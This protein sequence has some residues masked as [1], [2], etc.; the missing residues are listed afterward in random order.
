MDAIR[1]LFH[2]QSVA[3]VGASADARKLTGRPV[4]YLQ[5][6][7]FAGRIFPV[8]PRYQ[9]ISGLTCYP[10]LSALPMVPDVGLVLLGADRVTESI[11]Q[12][13]GAGCAAAI[14]LASG[15]GEAGDEGRRRQ[16]ELKEAAGSMRLLGP[17]TIG[18]VNVSDKIMLSASGAME[19][20]EFPAGNIALV[21]QSGGILGSLLS[22]AAAR[23]IGFSKLVATGNEADLD[24]TDIVEHLLDDE[25]TA[26]IALYLEGL[27]N[28]VRFRAVAARAAR[29][30]KPI[31]A[32]KVGR[33]ESG[34]RSA[35]SHTGA[36][37][38]ADRIYDAFFKQTGVVRAETFSDLLDIP[39]QLAQKR[40][41]HGHR[42]AIVTS[43]GGAATLVADSAGMAGFDT[44]D[45]DAPTAQ[46]L[47]SLDIRDAVLDR[48]PIDVT[49]AG[50]RPD[51]L[52][53]VIET[54]F[55][56]QSYDAVVVVVGSSALG[57]PDLVA[58]PLIEALEKTDKPL[59]AYV[60]PDA[61]HIV[62]HLNAHGVPAFAA[63]ESCAA[64]LSAML[65]VGASTE[66]NGQPEEPP[67]AI[68]G[69]LVAGSGPLNEAES[70]RLF[71]R[72][73]I[74]AVRE[75]AADSPQA[76]SAAAA[77]LGGNVVL[78]ILS[79]HIVHKTDVGG[80]AINV[81]PEDVGRRC[82]EMAAAVKRASSCELEGFLVQEMVTGGVELILGFHR[83]PQLGP[84]IVL[85][86]GGITA[87]LLR[88][89]AIRLPPVRPRDAAAMIDELKTSA[90]L[91]GFR[92]SPPADVGALAAAIVAFSTMVTALAD[93]LVEAEINPLFVL[94][95]GQG[96]R[97]A[98]GL[99]VLR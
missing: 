32:F 45:P 9:T 19:L 50:L 33:S 21:S 88:D 70:K 87:E 73:G 35:V 4:A 65:H 25:A 83:D 89:T 38:G 59:L 80:V 95:A 12:L 64:A 41:L 77:R 56:S 36:L 58:R 10:D 84:A 54:L 55:E 86:M 76:A 30:G 34:V 6:H 37:A 23:G 18:L 99:V 8:N 61:P 40:K 7:G 63:P 75:F 43:T 20:A 78:K 72:F 51:I 22:R 53:T 74:P 15:F 49:L 52:K 82:G 5:K 28:P 1:K 47:L 60:S 94:P 71:A 79:R 42:I 81:K 27:R 14:V 17:N 97:A 57:Q 26:V 44:P 29:I 24:V 69:D 85:G 96:V 13:A 67:P 92:G 66:R 48:N 16:Q 98:D 93:R 46:R 11:R 39:A 91:K 90:L 2:P 31:V 68:S 3:V 62:R